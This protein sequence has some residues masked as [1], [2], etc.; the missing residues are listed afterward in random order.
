M[1]KK[2]FTANQTEIDQ[3]ALKP[4]KKTNASKKTRKKT[5]WPPWPERKE[6]VELYEVIRKMSLS[7][8]I[9]HIEKNP[10]SAAAVWFLIFEAMERNQ[11]DIGKKRRK[12]QLENAPSQ[13]FR[14]DVKEAWTDWQKN[15]S[16]Y[17]LQKQ[18]ITAMIEKC[19]NI[20]TSTVAT[21]CREFK[22]EVKS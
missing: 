18:F 2:D 13:A 12:T 11:S 7:E 3:G 1:R 19:P 8:A 21:W 10:P 15:R 14:L 17:R 9:N 22:N 5:F 6:A 20:K 16:Q 4:Q